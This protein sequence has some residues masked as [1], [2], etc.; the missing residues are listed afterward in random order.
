M[1]L[2]KLNYDA[3]VVRCVMSEPSPG[4]LMPVYLLLPTAALMMDRLGQKGYII[5]DREAVENL[6]LAFSRKVHRRSAGAETG[7]RDARFYGVRAVVQQAVCRDA[8]VLHGALPA[9]V[10]PVCR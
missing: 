1:F 5:T 7:D 9:A 6:R 8:Q 2:A 4:T 3:R 10:Q